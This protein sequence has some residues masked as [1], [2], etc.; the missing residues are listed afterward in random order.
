MKFTKTLGMLALATTL[1]FAAMAGNEGGGGG[2]LCLEN[3]PCKTL[4]ETGFRIAPDLPEFEIDD[5]TLIALNEIL[6]EMPRYFSVSQGTVIGNKGDIVSLQIEDS[7][8]VNVFV[9]EYKQLIRKQ[10]PNFDFSN[11]ELLAFTLKGKTYLV[12]DKFQ[13][14]PDPKS[15]A[16]LLMHEAYIRV[17][18]SSVENALRMDGQVLDYVQAKRDKALSNF[19]YWEF[20]KALGRAKILNQYEINGMMAHDAV[21]KG[22]PASEL[23]KTIK[24]S[25]YYNH[26]LRTYP[27]Y[28]A[29]SDALGFRKYEPRF[30]RDLGDQVMESVGSANRYEIVS[31]AISK[32]LLANGKTRFNAEDLNALVSKQLQA[33]GSDVCGTSNEDKHVLTFKKLDQYTSALARINCKYHYSD[34]FPERVELNGSNFAFKGWIT[35]QKSS[36]Y[37]ATCK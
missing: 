30:A 37:Q 20:Y 35:C 23:L 4:A 26:D 21:R 25:A 12:L 32:Y 5:H 6:K 3:G 8:K 24:Q 14:M 19:D 29:Y 33:K 15:R 28:V 16:I 27:I 13:R 36:G 22:L 11:F 7:T 17:Y 1:S 2:G 34:L 9:E 18:K 10:S 31:D